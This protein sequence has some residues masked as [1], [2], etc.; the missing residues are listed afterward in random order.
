MTRVHQNCPS[1]QCVEALAAPIPASGTDLPQY[2]LAHAF[3]WNAARFTTL[4]TFVPNA[5]RK[6][7][8]GRSPNR[9]I[10][11]WHPSTGVPQ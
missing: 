5:V 4:K 10:V 3:D 8:S 6:R 9:S 11:P 1:C 7:A 2:P